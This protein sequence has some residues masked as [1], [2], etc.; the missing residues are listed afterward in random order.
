MTAIP[1]PA[2]FD[3]GRVLQRL[4]E[5]LSRNF[6]TFL[7]LSLLLVGLPT[8]TVGFLQILL[9]APTLANPGSTAAPNYAGFAAIPLIWLIGAAA[10]AVLQ[11]AVIHGAVSD[12]SGRKA[13]FGE[14][15]GTGLRNL[16][17]LVAVGLISAIC[18]FFGILVFIVP[19]VLLALAW[20]VATPALVV[21]R[22]GVFGAYARSVE[23]TR[24]CRI[25]IFAL[26]IIAAVVGFIFSMIASVFSVGGGLAMAAGGGA[27]PASMLPFLIGQQIAAF[28]TQTASAMINSAGI[29][30]VYYELRYVKEGVGAEQLAAVFD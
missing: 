23:L 13:S 14:A 7:L 20:A 19:G 29:A 27:N 18:I 4:F 12:L 25:Y 5:V 1:T 6:V 9:E 8:A 2:G 17:P 22:T 16:L 24:D 21:E 11:G 28:I 15:L 26:A 30:S 3:I 10:N